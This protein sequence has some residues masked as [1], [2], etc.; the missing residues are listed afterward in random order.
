[1]QQIF[2]EGIKNLSFECGLEHDLMLRFPES[3][4]LKFNPA[5]A[6]KEYNVFA[7][8][9]DEFKYNNK[10]TEADQNPGFS[11]SQ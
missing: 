7:I 5:Y 4:T 10:L 1:M 11:V 3:I 9:S 6:Q 8:P 2:N